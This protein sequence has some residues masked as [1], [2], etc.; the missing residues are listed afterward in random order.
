MKKWHIH[1]AL[2]IVAGVALLMVPFP[3][4]VKDML[5]KRHSGCNGKFVEINIWEDIACNECGQPSERYIYSKKEQEERK[6]VEIIRLKK[7]VQELEG[8][9][10]DIRN[11][12]G[13]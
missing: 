7:R 11:M 12:A 4:V 6:D 9:L 5:Y 10:V 1:I 8:K 2:F 13:G 3:H